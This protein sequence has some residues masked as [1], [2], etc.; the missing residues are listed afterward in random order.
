[1]Q[2]LQQLWDEPDPDRVVLHHLKE[3]RE[4]ELSYT[5]AR[6]PL[7]VLFA[8]VL[9]RLHGDVMK[10]VAKS[11]LPDLASI[12]VGYAVP[13]TPILVEAHT[14]LGE[15]SHHWVHDGSTMGHVYSLT[16][17]YF[18]VRPKGRKAVHPPAHCPVTRYTRDGS[19]VLHEANPQPTIKAFFGRAPPAPGP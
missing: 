13:S 16:R 9:N 15:V 3:I 5:C 19:L 6:L 12:V 2:L 17:S 8:Y 14:E 7:G 1:M 10:A 11:L 4:W 18:E